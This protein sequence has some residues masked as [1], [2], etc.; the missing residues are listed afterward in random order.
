MDDQGRW[1]RMKEK[2]REVRR[3]YYKLKEKILN[4]LND[5]GLRISKR[6]KKIKQSI[7]KQKD[8]YH[9]DYYDSIDDELSPEIT[10][11]LI[12]YEYDDLDSPDD[13]DDFEQ[14]EDIQDGCLSILIVD[15]L[16]LLTR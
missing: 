9:P 2:F 3:R 12:E 15:I 6:S 11:E 13:S 8:Q 1:Q 14:L 7:L 16:L 4:E 5:A 10:T